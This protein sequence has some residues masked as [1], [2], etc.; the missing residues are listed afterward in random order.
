VPGAVILVAAMLVVL[1][2]ALFAAGAAW[3]ALLGASLNSS[4]E[5]EEGAAGEAG[6]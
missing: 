6:D 1:P 2:S 5:A 3:S 4:A